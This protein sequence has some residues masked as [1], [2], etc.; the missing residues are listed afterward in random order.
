MSV[1]YASATAT[2]WLPPSWSLIIADRILYAGKSISATWLC[3]PS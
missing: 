3:N 1:L 2:T